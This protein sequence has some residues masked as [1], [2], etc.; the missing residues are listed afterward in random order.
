MKS[1]LDD[2]KRKLIDIGTCGLHV[3]HGAFRTGHEAA[4]WTINDFLRAIYMLFKDSPARKADFT[5]IT[6][7]TRF[8]KK[9]CSV[10]WVENVEVASRALEVLPHVKKYM[11][12]KS[13][14]LPKNS[15]CKNIQLACSDP[16]ICAKTQFFISIASVIEPF[17]RKY[18]TNNTMVPFM[19]NDLGSCVRNL[20]N[21]FVKKE[22]LAAADT[23]VGR[24]AYFYCSLG[25]DDS[26]TSC[27][28]CGPLGGASAWL[29][30]ATTNHMEVSTCWEGVHP[31]W[32]Q[33]NTATTRSATDKNSNKV[34]PKRPYSPS[35]WKVFL[36]YS[37][38]RRIRNHI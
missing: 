3:L 12:E 16:F 27:G 31:K 6:G 20:T 35:K 26:H 15:T 4:G 32:P 21:R 30:V 23:V 1:N 37:V 22:T 13:K 7:S 19:Y 9:F 38:I 17:L 2:C 34:M 18:Q 5:S 11:A 28:V 14:K 8:A 36:S 10:R 33:T 25:W 24:F 29:V